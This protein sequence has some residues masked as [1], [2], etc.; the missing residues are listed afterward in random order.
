MT[1]DTAGDGD[2][3]RRFEH[4]GWES[5]AAQYDT[6]FAR[7]TTQAVEPLLDAVGATRGTRLLDV[8]TGPGYVAGAAA[9]RGAQATGVDF[10]SSMVAHARRA[11]P[12]ADFREGDAEALDFAE[13]TF[14][15]VVMAYG[16]L[17][18]ARPEKAVREAARVL[19]PGGR[20]AFTAWCKP[21]ETVAYGIVLA[22]IQAH[23]N[24]DVQLPD[25]PFFFRF[26]DPAE[27]ERVMEQAGFRDVR[28]SR[29]PQSWRFDD[30]DGPL[31]AI[32]RAGVRVGA[33]LRAQSASAIASIRA[34]AREST[35]KYER[36]GAYVVPMPAI[37]TTGTL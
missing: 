25:G 13:G 18:L 9:R 16:I 32:F 31:D 6:A 36:D 2:A 28:V 15:A 33:I 23:G 26:G 37:L 35:R 30:A 10:S 27:C 8:A 7:L 11:H 29:V 20:F 4:A 12:G 34:A 17:H 21:E 14:D 5:N 1:S 19:K 24:M 3:F 22:A